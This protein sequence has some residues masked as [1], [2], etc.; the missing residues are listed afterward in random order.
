MLMDMFSTFVRPL[1]Q[2]LGIKFAGTAWGASSD[3]TPLP[4]ST[5]TAS[6]AINFSLDH[7]DGQSHPRPGGADVI[8][9]GRLAQPAR[10]P[11]VLYLPCN[12][13]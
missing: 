13:A 11:P 10:R 1:E 4:R 6:E 8:L 9:I 5:S 3:I 12:A 2:E 7:D